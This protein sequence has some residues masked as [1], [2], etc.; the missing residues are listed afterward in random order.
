[1]RHVRER[2][3]TVGVCMA[4]ALLA[5]SQGIAQAADTGMD[6]FFAGTLKITVPSPEYPYLAFRQFSADHTY[7]DQEGG[8]LFHGSWAIEGDRICTQRPGA[9]RYCNLGLGRKVG[10]SWT[11]KDPYTGNEV[12]FEL[13]PDRKPL[14]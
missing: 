11:D 4:V 8:N 6:G 9:Q 13:T 12:D 3:L 7:V 14:S 5:G 1:M 10:D 2:G